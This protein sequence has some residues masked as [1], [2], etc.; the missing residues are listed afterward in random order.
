MQW[1]ADSEACYAFLPDV[2]SLVDYEN[3]IHDFFKSEW[4]RRGWTLQELIAPKVLVFFTR[5]WEVLGHKCP[6]EKCDETCD[7]F[8]VSLNTK[9]EKITK[10]P[11][12]ILKCYHK[13][14]ARYGVEDKKRWAADRITTRPE[15]G[16]YCLLGLLNARLVPIYG[17][18]LEAWDR[19]EEIILKKA[20][21]ARAI[22][23]GHG[24]AAMRPRYLTEEFSARGLTRPSRMDITAA[25]EW[26]VMLARPNML[27]FRSIDDASFYH[28]LGPRHY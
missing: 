17:E 6:R 26:P 15:D 21:A 2:G 10:I 14:S 1:Y 16:A 23:L 22:D 11:A 3:A 7:G 19:L 8:G 9:I 28:Q 27:G 24:V 13:H 4:F 18:G 20:A 5:D 12:D 25:N